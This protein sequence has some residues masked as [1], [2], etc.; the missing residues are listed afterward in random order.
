[1]PLTDSGPGQFEE[2]HFPHAADE[3]DHGKGAQ[4]KD[5]RPPGSSAGQAVDT[6]GHDEIG[7]G[8]GHGQGDQRPLP[9]PDRLEQRRDESLGRHTKWHQRYQQPNLQRGG[10]EAPEQDR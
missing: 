3:R 2:G 1:M 6:Q 10:A 9:A 5:R 4:H 8:G 7:H